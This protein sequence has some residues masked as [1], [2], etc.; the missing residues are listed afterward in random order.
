MPESPE[1]FDW[2]ATLS[3]FCFVGKQGRLTAYRG[4]SSRHPKRTWSAHR[5]FH[6]HNYKHYLATTDHLTISSLEQA[7]A[8]LQAHMA[9]L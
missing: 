5:Y 7:A 6:Q 9:T 3:S 8:T 2:L 1:W 4:G